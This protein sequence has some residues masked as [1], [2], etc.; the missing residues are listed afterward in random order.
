VATIRHVGNASDFRRLE[1]G[2]DV[3]LPGLYLLVEVIVRGH[4][5]LHFVSKPY[6]APE[7]KAVSRER[8]FRCRLMGSHRRQQHTCS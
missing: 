1:G 3:P 7:S 2:M 4:H 6:G 8:F 5:K